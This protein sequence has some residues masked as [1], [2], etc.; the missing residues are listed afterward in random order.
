MGAP[1]AQQPEPPETNGAPSK[2]PAPTNAEALSAQ[3]LQQAVEAILARDFDAV[4]RSLEL[5]TAAG[6]D[7]PSVDRLRAMTALVRGDRA[8]AL[9]LLDKTRGRES[10]QGH[11]SARNAIA[12]A[13]VLIEA[14]DPNA[15]VREALRALALARAAGESAGEQAALATLAACY[16]RLGRD[17][18]A[19]ALA[20]LGTRAAL[21]PAPVGGSSGT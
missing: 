21:P 18:E 3:M 17:A 9:R 5:A 11:D 14:G 15:A 12:I 10:E 4:E 20:G 2:A 13:L 1:T 16:R 7:A 19:K 8:G 6:R